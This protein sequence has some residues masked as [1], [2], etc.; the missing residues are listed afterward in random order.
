MSRDIFTSPFQLPF[1][2]RWFI[3]NVMRKFVFRSAQL[4]TIFLIKDCLSNTSV[5]QRRSEGRNLKGVN[6][7]GGGGRMFLAK[8]C[9]VHKKSFWNLVMVK[10]ELKNFLN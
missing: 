4:L 7:E 1:F 5:V 8:N 6:K 2:L 10:F 3:N 9:F